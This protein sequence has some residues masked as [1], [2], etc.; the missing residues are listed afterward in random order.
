MNND[1]ILKAQEEINAT[2]KPNKKKIM[3]STG[4]TTIKKSVYAYPNDNDWCTFDEKC[5][6]DK[7]AFLP[8][9]TQKNLAGALPPKN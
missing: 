8:V 6:S 4:V 1:N 5:S 7:K 2:S 3:K 9:I